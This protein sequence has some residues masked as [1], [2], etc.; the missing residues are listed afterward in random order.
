MPDAPIVQIA[1]PPPLPHPVRY[2]GKV[3]RIVEELIRV[4]KQR[5]HSSPIAIRN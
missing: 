2:T 5:V 4:K 3:I 1:I